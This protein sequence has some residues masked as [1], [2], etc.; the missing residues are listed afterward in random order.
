[1]LGVFGGLRAHRVQCVYESCNN[2]HAALGGK[3]EYL[4]T[5]VPRSIH[6]RAPHI[7]LRRSHWA[8]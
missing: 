8:V 5:E 1:M 3:S 7:G 2:V 6:M 4:F